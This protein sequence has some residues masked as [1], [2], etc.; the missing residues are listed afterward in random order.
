M[1]QSVIDKETGAFRLADEFAATKDAA[2]PEVLAFFNGQDVETDDYRNGWTIISVSD[3]FVQG[4]YFNITFR[5]EHALLK[6]IDFILS[7]TPYA[8]S[9]DSW[10][11]WSHDEEMDKKD[12]Y[13]NWLT[14][15]VGGARKFHWGTVSAWFDERGGGSSIT[16][17]YS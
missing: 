3:H 4:H 5:F 7:P 17:R 11:N 8:L 15:Q 10:D 6:S 13:D 16:L 2:Y 14:T 9:T 1:P 12:R